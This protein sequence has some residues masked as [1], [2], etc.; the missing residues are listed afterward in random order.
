MQL[1]MYTMT[2]REALGLQRVPVAVKEAEGGG[3]SLAVPFRNARQ[4]EQLLRETRGDRVRHRIGLAWLQG[5][6]LNDA[7]A[8]AIQLTA[9][10]QPATS[11]P[12]Q[13]EGPS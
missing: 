9:L 2:L 4:L 6:K 13:A 1:V 11:P 10:P 8:A 7:P 12:A 5:A 3:Y